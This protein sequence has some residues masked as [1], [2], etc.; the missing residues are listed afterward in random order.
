M[1]RRH[2]MMRP[3][4]LAVDILRVP[5]QQAVPVVVDEFANIVLPPKPPTPSIN[6]R[7]DSRLAD[8]GHYTPL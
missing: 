7:S 2:D 4:R 1:H 5:V 3:A 8:E 6:K